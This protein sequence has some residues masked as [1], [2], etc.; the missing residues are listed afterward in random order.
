V[1]VGQRDGCSKE[2]VHLGRTRRSRFCRSTRP[3]SHAGRPR[4]AREGPP[5]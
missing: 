3:D 4:G 5:R 2:R 1:D